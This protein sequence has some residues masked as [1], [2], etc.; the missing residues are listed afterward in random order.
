MTCRAPARRGRV[1]SPRRD[2]EAGAGGA[3]DDRLNDPGLD[4]PRAGREGWDAV[5]APTLFQPRLARG[6]RGTQ[7]YDAAVVVDGDVGRAKFSMR[8]CGWCRQLNC[9]CGVHVV[10]PLGGWAG[11]T[12]LDAASGGP[13]TRTPRWRA[14]RAVPCPRAG[15]IPGDPPSDPGYHP[16]ERPRVGEVVEP[17]CS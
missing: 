17:T 7:Q 2:D 10:S 14:A 5:A 9:G 3:V 13:K 4:E 16:A 1:S 15:R 11:A 6:R 12:S 8:L